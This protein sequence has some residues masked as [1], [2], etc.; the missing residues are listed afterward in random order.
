[1]ISIKLNKFAYRGNLIL[2]DVDIQI[3]PGTINAVIG[4]NGCGKSTL[5]SIITGERKTPD[6][7]MHVSGNDKLNIGYV[8]QDNPLL[9]ET[10]GYDN[11]LL[12]YKGS[13]KSFNEELKSPL[14]QMLGIN[15]YIKKP[16]KKLSGGMK[17]RISIA[18]ALLNKPN[19]LIL[20]EPSAALD[21]VCKKDIRNYLTE[22]RKS[23]GTVIITTH[24]EEE[25]DLCDNIFIIK[26][27]HL[28]KLENKL[29][30]DELVKAITD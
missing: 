6:F 26:N 13:K 20:D 28:I 3:K 15:E 5:L 18:I 14:I 27:K 22:Y 23:G 30:G 16:I 8:P 25:L 9:A 21:L 10:T 12:W 1:M 7:S 19:L 17:K 2:E 29:K 4:A 11:L 24:D